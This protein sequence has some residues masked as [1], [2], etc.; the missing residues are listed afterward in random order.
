MGIKKQK[1]SIKPGDIFALGRHRLICG[2]ACD[3][4]TVSKL[5]GSRQIT[6]INTDVPYGVNYVAAKAGFRQKISCNKEIANDRMQSEEEYRKFMVKWL[7]LAAPRL[8]STNSCYI[9]NSD[10]MI[11]S[12]REAMTEAGFRFTQL[13][14]WIKNSA[15][16]GRLDYLPQHE[17]IAY[18]W[19]GKHEFSKSKDKSVIF[20]PRPQKSL[21]HPT[22]KPVS[23]I[24]RLI[25]NN[26][27][28]DDWVYD[29]FAGSGTCLVA[30]EQTRR[31]CLA[32]ELDPEYCNSIIDRFEK[33]TNIKLK[34]L[35]QKY[36]K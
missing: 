18:G 8:A 21:L 20:C 29:P 30:A 6:Q 32:I 23:L 11:F 26:T 3:Q 22:M 31:R 9:F 4:H 28:V 10:R 27:K 33:L 12:L 1:K 24:R 17:L 36:E 19:H 16:V 14:I 5:V 25:L 15:V 34:K 2:D 13:L 7:K 35:K